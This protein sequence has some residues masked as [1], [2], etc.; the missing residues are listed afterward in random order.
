MIVGTTVEMCDEEL[1]YLVHEIED[2]KKSMEQAE[3]KMK[4]STS[5]FMAAYSAT[6][7]VLDVTGKVQYNQRFSLKGLRDIRCMFCKMVFDSHEVRKR[8][9]INCHWTVFEATVSICY[10]CCKF[11]MEM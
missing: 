3:R 1:E 11:H 9:T 7:E 10:T 5:A 4:S 2:N 8:L 6:I